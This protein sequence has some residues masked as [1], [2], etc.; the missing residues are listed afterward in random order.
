[1]VHALYLTPTC[2]IPYQ[3]YGRAR[4]CCAPRSV[5]ILFFCWHLMTSYFL[6]KCTNLNLV[7]RKKIWYWTL[8]MYIFYSGGRIASDWCLLAFWIPFKPTLTACITQV[9]LCDGVAE[10]Y[11]FYFRYQ[12]LVWYRKRLTTSLLKTTS[13][14]LLFLISL[15]KDTRL[16]FPAK[17]KSM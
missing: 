14:R 10:H 2:S 15:W 16:D 13:S 17:I 11:F 12:I 1:M 8:H 7:P 3:R 5:I 4:L 9:I 6:G